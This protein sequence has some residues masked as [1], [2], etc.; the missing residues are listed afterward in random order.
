MQTN[1]FRQI[2]RL[3]LAGDL[4]ITLRP[5]SE[6]GFVLFQRNLLLVKVWSGELLWRY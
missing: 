1:F 3:N 2:A 4:Q 6:N 5:T